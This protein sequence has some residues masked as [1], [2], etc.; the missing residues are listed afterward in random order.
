MTTRRPLLLVAGLALGLVLSGPAAASDAGPAY[1]PG[2]GA[3]G[4]VEAG[5][6]AGQGGTQG[7][8][9]GTAPA[10]AADDGGT[11][12]DDPVATSDGAGGTAATTE[13]TEVGDPATADNPGP[14]SEDTDGTAGSDEETATEQTGTERAAPADG[15]RSA[16][17]ILVVA[18]TAV[19][20]AAGVV[21]IARRI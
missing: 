1:P 20:L 4:V 10:G 9:G 17:P 14:E 19:L 11:T 13:P 6:G 5:R 16:G 21:A 18:G 2:A 3:D 7:G 8:A 12:G 15:G